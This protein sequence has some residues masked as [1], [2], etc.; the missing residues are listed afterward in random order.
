MI[1]YAKAGPQDILMRITVHNRGP[2][3]AEIQVLP[4]IFFRNV[5]S[6]GY[7]TLKPSLKARGGDAI[8]VH[9]HELGEYEFYVEGAKRSAVL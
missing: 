9:H 8:T 7:E 2:E 4:Q 1:E 6:W 3:A 5:W